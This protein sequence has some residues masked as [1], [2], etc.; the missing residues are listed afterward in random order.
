MSSWGSLDQLLFVVFPYLVFFIFFY[1]TI[2]RYRQTGFT[3]SSLSSPFLENPQHF[4]DFF[5]FH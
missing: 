4:F 5:P 3:Y 1:A 2:Q